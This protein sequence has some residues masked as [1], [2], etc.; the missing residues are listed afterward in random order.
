MAT[1][2]RSS[3]RSTLA[4]LAAVL[5]LFAAAPLPSARA[6]ADPASDVL[7]AQDVFYPYQPAVSP[8]LS[9]AM[10]KVL[11]D[12]KANGLGLKVAILDNATDLGAV[13]KLFNQPQQYADF[14][15]MEI[16]FNTKQPL[17]VVMPAGFGVVHAGPQG[18]LNGLLADAGHGADG[19]T[20]SAIG[21]VVKLAAASGHPIAAPAIPS[22]GASGG[23]H[24]GGTSPLLTFGAPVALVIIAAGVAALLRSRSPRDEG[25][26]EDAHA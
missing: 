22:P 2:L 26:T 8:A 21:A 12:A 7:L 5:V 25:D 6:D 18:A 15:D 24:G 13:T 1:P 9:K 11:A 10:S 23:G 19:L 20:R 16:S 4:A 14:L 3:P 17:L